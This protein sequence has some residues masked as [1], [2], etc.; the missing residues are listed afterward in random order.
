[1]KKSET[2]PEKNPG[3]QKEERVH[4]EFILL[5]V[6]IAVIVVCFLFGTSG[7]VMVPSQ[8]RLLVKGWH[9]ED[10]YGR[11]REIDL[12]LSEGAAPD[13]E[14][15]TISRRLPETIDSDQVLGVY[16]SF[17]EIE[18]RIGGKAVERYDHNRSLLATNIPAN[19]MRMIKLS[20]EDGGHLLE[21]RC[22]SKLT[23]YKLQLNPVLLGNRAGIIG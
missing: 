9:Y 13:L 6:T 22:S 16:S 1:M 8:C 11:V 23:G 19:Q 5:S 7:S 18:V 12:P 2:V 10:T 15:V 20:P 17:Q 21:I 3:M 4:P 14:A